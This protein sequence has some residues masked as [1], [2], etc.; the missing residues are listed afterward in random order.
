MMAPEMEPTLDDPGNSG[1]SYGRGFVGGYPS[2]DTTDVTED[3]HLP[4]PR[5]SDSNSRL[6]A[7]RTDPSADPYPAKFDT[8]TAAGPSATYRTGG[9][10]AVT[11]QHGGNA[12]APHRRRAVTSSR[13]S[14]TR[15]P[16]VRLRLVSVLGLLLGATVM[17]ASAALSQS[18]GTQVPVLSTLAAAPVPPSEHPMPERRP[19]PATPGTCLAWR[20]DDAT[21]AAIVDCAGPHLFEQAGAVTLTQ[22]GP[23]APLPDNQSFRQLVNEQCTGLVTSYLHG[24]YDPDGAFRAGALKPSATAWFSGNRSMRCGL[25]RFSRSGALYSIKGKVAE[26][27]QSNIRAAGLCLG[28]DGKFIGD[29][30]SCSRPHA[31]QSVGSIDL[32]SKFSKYPQVSDQ[33]NYLQPQCTKLASSYAGGQ[34]A[35]A[36]KNLSVIWDNLSQD[37]W[38]AGTRKVPC[39]LAAQLPDHSGFAPI[40]GDAKGKVTV[41]DLAAPPAPQTSAPGAPADNGDGAVP[42]PGSDQQANGSDNPA[43]PVRKPE[44]PSPPSQLNR[45]PR[46]PQLPNPFADNN[47][48]PQPNPLDNNNPRPNPLGDNNNP[49]SNPL[50]GDNS[51]PLLPGAAPTRE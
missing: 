26:L 24:R 16:M 51:K 31:V 8:R 19:P 18:T 38:N 11:S 32:S 41:G 30:V 29:P 2:P 4:V 1:R 25:Q 48:N 42:A 45:P 14:G 13:T 49:R 47:G 7:V 39:N 34:Q 21:D 40:T 15:P 20:R 36:G 6:S 46:L 23:D 33:D 28:I 43:N 10:P 22:Y 44:L 50:G 5:V 37:S 35:L 27:D 17:L 3:P 9:T 12:A